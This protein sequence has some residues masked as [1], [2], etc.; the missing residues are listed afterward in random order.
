MC[1]QDVFLKKTSC[2]HV[3]KTEDVLEDV[4]KM[5]WRRVKDILKM[6]WRRL[7]DVF[8]RH[9]ANKSWIRLQYVLKVSWKMKN[10]YSSRRLQEIWKIRNV[11]WE[12]YSRTASSYIKIKRV[13][14]NQKSNFTPWP[15]MIRFLWLFW[16]NIQA[17]SIKFLICPNQPFQ[18]IT[19]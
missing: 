9:L 17:I 16:M 13:L 4:L 6:Y 11:C 18:L 2:E 10:C 19:K 15:L 3:L 5:F 12:T 14:T 7:E 8:G 1:L